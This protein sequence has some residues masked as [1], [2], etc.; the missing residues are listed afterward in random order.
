MRLLLATS[1]VAAAL[2][3]GCVTA[4][5]EAEVETRLGDA[6]R[7]TPGM[8]EARLI[9]IWAET[10]LVATALLTEARH[11]PDSALSRQVSARLASAARRRTPVVVGG[12]YPD[13]SDRVLLNAITLQEELRL[14]GLTVLLVSHEGPSPEL[15]AAARDAKTRLL[16]RKTY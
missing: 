9:P 13:L 5:T 15:V 6:A 4:L 10:R 16:H 3:L 1:C 8:D 11:D 14:R 12:P 7:S 2:A